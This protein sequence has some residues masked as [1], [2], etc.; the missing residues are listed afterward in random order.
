[1]E[2]NCLGTIVK[3]EPVQ[4]SNFTSITIYIPN[5]AAKRLSKDKSKLITL[6]WRKR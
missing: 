6:K 1:M 3:N 4:G 2:D 5:S